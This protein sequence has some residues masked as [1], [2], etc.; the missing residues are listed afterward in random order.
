M[1]AD[2]AVFE[3]RRGRILAATLGFGVFSVSQSS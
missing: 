1:D 3:V 2:R